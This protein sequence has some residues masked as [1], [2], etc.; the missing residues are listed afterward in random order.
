MVAAL[1]DRREELV[2]LR[3]AARLG[4]E[5]TM[6]LF[7]TDEGIPAPAVSSRQVDASAQTNGKTGRRALPTHN[8][9]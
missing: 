1:L 4:N 6:E 9:G 8:M 7:P 3:L 5:R 2:F